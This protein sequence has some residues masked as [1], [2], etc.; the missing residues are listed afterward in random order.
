MHQFT[1]RELVVHK[2][3]YTSQINLFITLPN[4]TVCKKKDFFI[5]II[6]CICLLMSSVI[7]AVSLTIPTWNLC[8][9][10]KFEPMDQRFGVIN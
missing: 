7:P 4:K 6:I 1:K 8:R 9:N 2:Y 5:N 3:A 10:E